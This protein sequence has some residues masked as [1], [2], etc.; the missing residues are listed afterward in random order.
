[1]C[2]TLC[3]LFYKKIFA[4][5][6]SSN[7][8]YVSK[9]KWY[10][11]VHVYD[12]NGLKFTGQREWNLVCMFIHHD[13]EDVILVHL[14]LWDEWESPIRGKMFSF[15][16]SFSLSLSLLMIFYTCKLRKE[17]IEN[18]KIFFHFTTSIVFCVNCQNFN[19]IHLKYILC[20]YWTCFCKFYLKITC[21]KKYLEFLF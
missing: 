4:Y 10:N 5:V 20:K 12:R 11:G 13:V 21:T 8:A 7:I 17:N 16:N 6:I 14:Y 19:F 1:M 9:I 3:F 15:M 2:C 18:S